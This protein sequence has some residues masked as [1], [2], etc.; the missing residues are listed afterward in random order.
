MWNWVKD[1]IERARTFAREAK[2]NARLAAKQRRQEEEL[3]AE[4]RR[5][6]ARIIAATKAQHDRVE[7]LKRRYW[8]E[9]QA[10]EEQCHREYK[11]EADRQFATEELEEDLSRRMSRV[12]IDL[13]ERYGRRIGDMREEV[14]G[15]PSL[16]SILQE[17]LAVFDRPY[18]SELD[19]LHG[20]L[21]TLRAQMQ[22]LYADKSAAHARLNTAKSDIESWHSKSKR[23]PWLFGNGGKPLPKHSLF[24]QSFGDLD[25]YKA[26]RNA[27]VR[28]IDRISKRIGELK[29]QMALLQD[30]ISAVKASR[31]KMFD[32]RAEG[33][34]PGKIKREIRR[35]EGREQDLYRAI[36]EL[37][38][39]QAGAFETA[40]AKNGVAELERAI[41]DRK[42]ART[43]YM[44]RFQDKQAKATRKS[45][46][47]NEWI[48]KHGNE[49]GI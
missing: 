16:K 27:A 9:Y 12:R 37:S 7:A 44:A 20:D 21:T 43:A 17:Q 31:Q 22:Q 30:Q 23:T 28:D 18:K 26:D 6:E 19:L 15:L 35:V 13:E 4:K 39:T 36:A 32:F 38:A 41:L 45:F 24:G 3:V 47:R 8:S 48:I 14:R 42:A 34:H 11:A 25:G 29:A 33:N 10:F 1:N 46:Y 5:E 49:V 40:R 2:E